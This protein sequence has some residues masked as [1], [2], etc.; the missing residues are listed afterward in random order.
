MRVGQAAEETQKKVL[1]VLKEALFRFENKDGK[2]IRS[3]YYKRQIAQIETQVRDIL[4]SRTYTRP[5]AEYLNAFTTIEARNIAMQ[6]SVND[7]EVAVNKLAPARKTVFEQAQYYL[8]G[9]GLA[10]A[11]IQP[12]KYLLMQQ[13]TSGMSITDSQKLLEKWDRGELTDG[14]LTAGRQTPNLQRYATQLSRDMM[15]QFNGTVNDIIR[16]EYELEAFI[17]TGDIIK[18]SR[19][20]CKHLVGLDREIRFDELLKLLSQYPQGVIPGTDKSNFLV[21]RGGYSCRHGAMP[22]KNKS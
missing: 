4:G 7:L 13:V 11:Y 20:L 9:A 17:Y 18:D 12:A 6:R 10:D 5:I 3:Q 21:Y 22:V 16:T 1:E 8:N 2:F 15:Y 14:K 19:P